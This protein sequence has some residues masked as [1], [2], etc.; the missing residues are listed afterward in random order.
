MKVL[1]LNKKTGEKSL[2]NKSVYTVD[3]DGNVVLADLKKANYVLVTAEEEAAFS[4]KVVS[5]VKVKQ[6]KKSVAT[7]NKNGV[8]KAKVTLKNGKT[9]TVKMTVT[10]KKNK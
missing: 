2:I 10:V 8:I 4:K 3:E 5:T 6:S 7:V 9:K 1:K